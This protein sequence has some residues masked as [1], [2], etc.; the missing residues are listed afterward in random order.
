M[1]LGIGIGYL[2]PEVSDLINKLSI[3]TKYSFAI[4][5]IVMMYPPL[6]K[7]IIHYCPKLSKK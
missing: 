1:L 6:A 2:I 5:L 7:L 3:G 4:G